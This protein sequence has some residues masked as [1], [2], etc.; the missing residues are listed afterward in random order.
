MIHSIEENRLVP[1]MLQC[2]N[3]ALVLFVMTNNELCQKQVQILHDIE[4]EYNDKI[5]IYKIDVE[6][7]QE[8]KMRYQFTS[9]P[10]LIFFKNG[11]EIERVVGIIE[12]ET[13]ISMIKELC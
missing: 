5:D 2:D 4:K 6:D 7:S 1:E 9:F 11:E 8:M 3:L 12:N 13:L 10:S